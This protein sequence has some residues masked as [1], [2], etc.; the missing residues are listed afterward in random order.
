MD[1]RGRR[2]L[3]V[4]GFF[5]GRGTACADARMTH[6]M[7][8]VQA[9]APGEPRQT[10]DHHKILEALPAADAAP[11]PGASDRAAAKRAR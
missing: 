7:Q 1:R 6:D 4:E 8:P 9:K 2:A 10:W 11:P 5:A 3:P